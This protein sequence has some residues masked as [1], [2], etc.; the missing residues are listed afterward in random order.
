MRKIMSLICIAAAM[1]MIS[2]ETLDLNGVLGA[3]SG[4]LDNSTIV[5][6]LKDAL[7]VGTKKAVDQVSESGGFL[8][9]KK[10][11]L[12][13]PEELRTVTDTLR[14][15][16]LGNL[17]DDF[18]KKMNLAAEKASGKAIPIF[19]DAIT[20]MSFKDAS[21][22]LNEKGA[23]A[24]EYFRTKTSGKLNAA[25]KPV[26]KEEMRKVGVVSIYN[27]LMAK[28]NMIPFKEKPNFNLEEYIASKTLGGLFTVLAKE[29]RLIRDDPA[30]RT[31]TL[32]KKVFGNNAN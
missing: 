25:F 18:E 30:A 31:T 9:N 1:M 7:I 13:M 4:K 16:G 5:A 6:G 32:L 29:E 20:Q 15:I 24:T 26:I 28:Y 3:H 17:V 2:C 21:K 11:Y 27:D 12:A 8:N 23:P 10:I 14:K 19:S 22:I